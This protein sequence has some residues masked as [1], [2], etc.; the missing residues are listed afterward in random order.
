MAKHNAADRGRSSREGH[1][2]AR[3]A[4][5][6]GAAVL[7]TGIA[8][9]PAASAATPSDSA[10][11]HRLTLP[12]EPVHNVGDASA[13][14]FT[15]DNE[16]PFD[17]NFDTASTK[18]GWSVNPN[19]APAKAAVHPVGKSTWSVDDT[20]T[21]PYQFE[22]AYQFKD[23]NGILNTVEMF[24]S[25]DN[26]QDLKCQV[27]GDTSEWTCDVHLS[28][29]GGAAFVLHAST[30]QMDMSKAAKDDFAQAL[31]GLC[32]AGEAGVSCSFKP[33]AK[34]PSFAE[35]ATGFIPTGADS[36]PGCF[37]SGDLRDEMDYT[38]SA[39]T[40]QTMTTSQ[41]D[42]VTV[43]A[44]VF[45]IANA[46]FSQSYT[47]GKEFTHGKSY[48]DK[49]NVSANYGYLATPYW[50]P[51]IGTA[52]GDFTATLDGTTYSFGD[53]AISTAGAAGETASGQQ[54]GQYSADV[55]QAQMTKAQFAQNCQGDVPPTWM[56]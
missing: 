28:D 56:K 21:Q 53:V 26:G 55:A 54:L 13:V 7:M 41:T 25:G 15:L 37:P 29:Q 31:N 6:I 39:E 5:V 50:Y 40:S 44:D 46:A 16:T 11:V 49:Q 9:A 48:S 17:L 47:W 4:A 12:K 10:S 3:W 45:D 8:S 35:S 23:Q 27:V 24:E 30:H 34:A 33:D 1:A 18:S 51:T 36:V 32:A 2:G 20:W 38:A 14:T 42:T 43:N 22:V 19:G 52:S